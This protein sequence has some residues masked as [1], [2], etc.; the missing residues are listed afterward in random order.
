MRTT[1]VL[2]AAALA[3]GC[4]GD[5]AGDDGTRVVAAVYPLAFVAERVGADRV[6]VD[7]LAAPGV[8]PHDLELDPDQVDDLQT[9]DLV[10]YVGGGFQPAVEDALG[11]A[12]GEAVD[13]LDAAGVA[14][15][16]PHVWLD[17]VLLQDV[18]TAVADALAGVD[19]AG[20]DAYAG[21]A[22]R[23]VADLAALDAELR[24]GLAACEGRLL[25]TT[26]AAFGH[27]AARYGL[28][29]EGVAGP[30]PEAEADPSRIA[31][32]AD[33]VRDR[34]VATVFSEALLP[35]DVVETLADEAGV[36]TAVLHP[37]ENLTESEVEAGADYL[38]VM[39]DNL[40]TLQDGLG[41]GP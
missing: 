10:L 35:P 41:C 40:A 37:L 20:D 23:L 21:A 22:E 1:A 15:D 30:T 38:S 6:S 4:G 9:A 16:D 26:H 39:R 8:E 2:L 19:P 7:G 34:G 29:Q 3:A 33:L 17:P 31:E 5:A 36:A 25:V 13:A 18:A 28:E 14:G 12:E 11:D 24:D 27:L 32:L